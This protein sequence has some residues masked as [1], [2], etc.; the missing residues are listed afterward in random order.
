M[1]LKL[2]LVLIPVSD[3]DRGKVFYVEKAGFSLVVRRL[4]RPRRQHLGPSG[5][6]REA[7]EM[8]GRRA[9]RV[10]AS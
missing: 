10:W 6:G 1:D 8:T 7:G 9:G 4:Q 3:V 5:E 2:E